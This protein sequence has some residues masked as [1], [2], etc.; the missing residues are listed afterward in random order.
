[1]TV[2]GTAGKVTAGSAV[3]DGVN[4]TI[5]TGGANAVT[6]DGAAGTVKLVL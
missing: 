4:N 2:D 6:M 5:T 3:V 1:M